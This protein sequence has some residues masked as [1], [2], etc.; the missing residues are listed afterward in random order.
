MR[1]ILA[2][3]FI[4]FITSCKEEKSANI[5]PTEQSTEEVVISLK[6]SIQKIN[7]KIT[8]ISE[9]Q[10]RITENISP[11]NPIIKNIEKEY[12]K[13]LLLREE[14]QIQVATL[15]AGI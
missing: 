2:V 13:L 12:I 14:L 10:E 1:A 9:Q 5:L 4:V 3:I 7:D 15:E 8:E 11:E 6:D